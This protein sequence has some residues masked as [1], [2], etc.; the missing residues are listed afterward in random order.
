MSTL[1]L[2]LETKLKS[3]YDEAI[4]QLSGPLDASSATKIA[5]LVLNPD[6]N[7]DPLT[8][9]LESLFL[10]YLKDVERTDYPI[11]FKLLST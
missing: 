10:R 5:I 11:R 8:E 1:P 2:A 6:R 9:K 7:I 3:A 4:E